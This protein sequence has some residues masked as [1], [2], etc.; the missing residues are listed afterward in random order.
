MASRGAKPTQEH[1]RLYRNRNLSMFLEDEA[2]VEE[3]RKHN[4]GAYPPGYL[5]QKA[6]QTKAIANAIM[7]EYGSGP[8]TRKL[9]DREIFEDDEGNLR[10]VDMASALTAPT[11][12]VYIN[13][14]GT[15][16]GGHIETLGATSPYY[17]VDKAL[18]DPVQ[19]LSH[20]NIDMNN[21]AHV[22]V[23][24][25]VIDPN[26]PID[27]AKEALIIREAMQAED[28]PAYARA[29]DRGRNVSPE[30][31]M[32]YLDRMKRMTKGEASKPPQ[33][34]KIAN[35][36]KV[37]GNTRRPD[38]HLLAGDKTIEELNADKSP[39]GRA[40]NSELLRRRYGHMAQKLVSTGF[41]SAN[42]PTPGMEIPGK[43]LEMDHA[44]A[45]SNVGPALADEPINHTF[46]HGVTNGQTK[47]DRTIRE[48]HDLIR[49]GAELKAQGVQPV[50]ARKL[51]GDDLLT[52]LYI[53]SRQQD[54]YGRLLTKKMAADKNALY[55]TQ[56]M[57]ALQS[58]K[59]SGVR[60]DS[61][62]T[63]KNIYIDADPGSYVR[64]NGNGK[65]NGNG[66]H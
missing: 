43:T 2:L 60:M 20:I 54:E 53:D 38:I 61:P 31:A 55:L 17:L 23:A 56:S 14:D 10:S 66:K 21:P 27:Q 52:Q 5:E 58:M 51:Q 3:Y 9:D 15:V 62:G 29:L 49:M 13:D 47:N 63:S 8:K 59:G 26:M 40:I 33:A 12:R 42:D 57:D 28:A 4:D 35:Y 30:Y 18:G 22:A 25:G 65:S 41:R 1:L 45:Y 7:A 37:A 50:D 11:S 64:V 48:T 46:L 44:A 36:L 16:E 34:E 6:A 39:E 24:T 19:E 32:A